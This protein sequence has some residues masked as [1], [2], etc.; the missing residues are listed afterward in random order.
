MNEKFVHDNDSKAVPIPAIKELLDFLPYAST[1]RVMI[2]MLFYTGCRTSEL[3]HMRPEMI[4]DRYIYWELG[5]NQHHHRKEPLPDAFLDEI[6]AYRETHRVSTARVFSMTSESLRARFNHKIRPYLSS[7]WHEKRLVA[8]KGC[9]MPEYILQLKGL[10]KTHAT[11]IF[12]R[13]FAKWKSADVALEFTSKRMNHSTTHMTAYH[14]LQNFDALK[15]RDGPLI[16]PQQ[17][18]RKGRQSRLHDF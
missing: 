11:M 12:S 18:L 9:L 3:N 1:E 2:E 10:R 14:Y 17:A 4:I 15:I 7:A 16:L 13:E 6:R 8:R 5:K